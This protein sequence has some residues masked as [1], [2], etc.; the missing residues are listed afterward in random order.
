MCVE[1]G[2][3]EQNRLHVGRGDTER[4]GDDL[5][6]TA[7]ASEGID[8]DPDRHGRERYGAWIR[9][10]STSRPRY[11]LQFGQTWCGRFGWR[12]VGQTWTRGVESACC[13]R[14]LSRLD[15]DVLRFG[16]AMSG[17]GV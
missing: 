12:Q 15:L 4:T 7:I 6:W 14:R 8:R 16:T 1:P 11:V 10:G 17:C 3:T 5:L 2:R 13:A 9:S